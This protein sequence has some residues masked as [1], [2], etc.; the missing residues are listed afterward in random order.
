MKHVIAGQTDEDVIEWRLVLDE[1]GEPLL[2]VRKGGEHWYNVF[3]VKGREAILTTSGCGP[4]G[5]K[6]EIV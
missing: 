2:Q 1:C 3:W 5:L 6:A 4:L